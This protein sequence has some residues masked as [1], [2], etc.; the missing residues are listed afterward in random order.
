MRRKLF[1]WMGAVLLAVSLAG[2]GESGSEVKVPVESAAGETKETQQKNPEKA[3]IGETVLVDEAGVKITAKELDL[4]GLFGPE[5]K[6]LIENESG[7]DLTIQTRNTSI[8]GYMV[9]TMMSEDVVNG[10]KVNADLTFLK[11][12]LKSCG[13]ETIADMEVSFHIF[14]SDWETYL[15]TPLIQLKTT[16]ADT[17]EYEFDSKGQLVYEENGIKIVVR[18]L[19]E[20]AILG[21]EMVVYMENNSETDI[22]VQVRDVS[23]NGFMVETIFSSDIVVGKHAIDTIDI[24]RSSLEE[25]QITDVENVELSFHIFNSESWST[26]VDT[27]MIILNF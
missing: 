19:V 12:D 14:T 17:Y 4:N 6:L 2:C 23:V 11:S 24:L 20:N 27:D 8:N 21:P 7:E 13:I 25:N 26:I 1:A 3:E 15:D 18:E 5:L 22:T 16:V 9:D 10:K